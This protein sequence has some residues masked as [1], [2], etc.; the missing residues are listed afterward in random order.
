MV[1]YCRKPRSNVS[2]I[3]GRMLSETVV[4]SHRYTHAAC[5]DAI[6]FDRL[7]DQLFSNGSLSPQYGIAVKSRFAESEIN[8]FSA[9]ILLSAFRKAILSV[10]SIVLEYALY[11]VVFGSTLSPVNIPRPRSIHHPSS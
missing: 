8:P 5:I 9:N 6:A 10:L 11:H 3:T 4:G 1:E 7:P 2:G